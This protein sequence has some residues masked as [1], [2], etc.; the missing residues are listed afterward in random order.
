MKILFKSL[1]VTIFVLVAVYGLMNAFWYMPSCR[2][3]GLPFWQYSAFI[4][5]G[6][7]GVLVICFVY[8]CICRVLYC[9]IFHEG[10]L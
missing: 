5:L 4:L 1:Y 8:L 10:D 9:L 6:L 3:M 2:D 7:V